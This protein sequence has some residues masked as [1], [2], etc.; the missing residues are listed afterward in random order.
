M[1]AETGYTVHDGLTVW[2]PLY[3]ILIRFFSYIFEPPILA[4]LVISSLS[5]WVA[6]I[7]L[8]FLIAESHNESTAKN[9]LLLYVIYPSAF[10]LVAGYSESFFLALVVGC[11]LLARRGYWL[12]AGLLAA[13]ATLTRN[14]GIVLAAVLFWEGIL[15]YREGRIH[16]VGQ[17][18]KASFASLLPVLTFGLFA[19]YVHNV[20]GEGWPWETLATLWGQSTGL[21]W[22][23]MIGNIKQLLTLPSSEDLYWLPT[24]ILDLF[25]AIVI[26]IC[27]LFYRHSVRS[28]YFVLAWLILFLGLIKLGPDDTLVSFSRYMLAAFAFFLVVS[29]LMKDRL[30]RMAVISFG[31]IFQAILLS[32]FYIWSWAG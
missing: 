23:G 6:F 16:N 7:L 30:F 31:L 11:L 22:E 2:P 12:W 28:T 19:L 9:T 4:A 25:F 15:Q 24:T 13:L 26:P 5:T 21:P 18:F 10:F 29:P 17:M 27:L 14:Q 8:Y 1:I 20:L 32:M 3:P